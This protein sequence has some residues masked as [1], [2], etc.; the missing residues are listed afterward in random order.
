MPPPGGLGSVS[1]AHLSTS[2]RTL[3]LGPSSLEL[4][5]VKKHVVSRLLRSPLRRVVFSEPPKR[6]GSYPRSPD[7]KVLFKMPPP[8]GR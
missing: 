3:R 1:V 8:G 4:M 6:G 5:G 7:S 2:G